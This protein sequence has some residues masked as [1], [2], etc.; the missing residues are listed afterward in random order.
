MTAVLPIAKAEPATAAGWREH[1]LVLAALWAALLLLFRRDAAD[2][3]GIWY[4][5]STFNHCLLIV[6]LI[7]WLVWQR[8]PELRQVAPAAWTPGLLLVAAGACAWLLGEAGGLSLARHAGLVFMLQGAVVAC[9]GK[10]VAR[11]LLFPLAYALF[12]IPAGEELVPPMQTLTAKMSM[13]LLGLS[14]VPAHIEGIF[15][16]TPTGLFQV[17]E[18]C[19]GVK[20]LVAMVAYGALAAN[21]CFHSWRRRLAFLAASILVPVLANGVRAWGTMYIAYR[22]HSL[23][24][25]KSF[26][27]VF[28]GWIF[29]AI[30]IA[31]VMGAAWPFFDRKASD[32]WFDPADLQPPGTPAGPRPRL[33][34]T[35]AAAFALAAAAPLWSAALAAT[36][37]ASVPATVPMP[38]VPG[39][40]QVPA[41]GGRAW[42]PHFAGADRIASARYRDG[43]G[44]AVD[45]WLIVYARQEAGRKLIGFG[46]G[47]AEPGS[48]WAWT[49]DA[50]PPPSGKSERIFSNGTVREV[51][52]F[53]R[54]GRI[55]T[56]SPAEVK[57]ETMKTHLLG[58]PQRAVAVLVSAEEPAGQ[59]SARPAIDAFLRA[60]GPVAPL[61]DAAAG[62]GGGR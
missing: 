8:W 42:T 43:A 58:G 11:G 37:T 19:S 17:A 32:P 20:F 40:Q 5:S 28:Y 24:F 45:L 1:G 4:Y 51:A 14:G 29:F 59:G 38:H 47:A 27:H 12:L 46:Q 22:S 44:R 57:L 9:L 7:G 61:A 35:A 55:L 26:D 56:G 2:I 53:Y 15:I 10:A 31:I 49:T 23:A 3:V 34:A 18:A 25:A 48:A 21:L 50:P 13:V 52:S 6:P 60:L 16:T 39:W 41:D 30:V 33:A 62:V 36:G 54:V